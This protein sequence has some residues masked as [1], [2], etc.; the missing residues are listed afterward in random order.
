VKHKKW[1]KSKQEKKKEVCQKRSS[2]DEAGEGRICEAKRIKS[3][4]SRKK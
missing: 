3:W 1:E 4:W 2:V